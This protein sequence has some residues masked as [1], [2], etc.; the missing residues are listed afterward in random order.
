MPN[1]MEADPDETDVPGAALLRQHLA[2]Y[3]PQT[4]RAYLADW[5]SWTLWCR[6]N[7]RAPLPAHPTDVALYLA[8]AHDNSGTSQATLQRWAST[9][10]TAHTANGYPAPTNQPP[11]PELLRWLRQT[12]PRP[13]YRGSRWLTDLELTRVLAHTREE[14][15]PELVI[16]RRDR[17]IMLLTRAT[18]DGP[19]EILGL[20]TGQ[21]LLDADTAILHREGQAPL[22]LTDPLPA[23]DWTTCLPCALVLWRQVLD[24]ADDDTAALRQA[25]GNPERPA[26]RGHLDHTL[27]PAPNPENWLLRRVRRGGTV[28]TNRMASEAIRTLLRAHATAAGVETKG[29]T[30]FALR[31]HP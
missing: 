19:E 16:H 8:H 11:I 18:G 24:L 12:K 27:E 17:L 28:T 4:R 26:P 6:S 20:R 22:T 10:A 31:P 2:D 15:W 14:T 3:A 30:A 7:D 13:R 5:K 1:T 25:L 29:L 23:A 9:I 21:L